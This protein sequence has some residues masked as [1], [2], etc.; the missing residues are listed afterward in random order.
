M[1][2]ETRTEVPVTVPTSGLIE[3]DV[4]P[5]TLQDS[6]EPCPAWMEGGVDANDW[7][8]GPTAFVTVTARV[9]VLSPAAF[10]AVSV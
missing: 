3:T 4:A 2:G 1:A 7:I 8:V 5:D 9:A 10:V 6:V